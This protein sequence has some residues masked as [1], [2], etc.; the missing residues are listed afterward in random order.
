MDQ[1]AI[2]SQAA[3]GQTKHPIREVRNRN[4]TEIRHQTTA[5]WRKTRKRTF[6]G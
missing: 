6:L 5:L 1:M 3:A 2:K 4:S